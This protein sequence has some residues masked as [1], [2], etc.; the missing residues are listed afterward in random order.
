LHFRFA[1]LASVA[2]TLV[3]LSVAV[4]GAA[5]AAQ[6]VEA[7]VPSQSSPPPGPPPAPEAT[8]SRD[9]DGGAVIKSGDVIDF[10]AETMSY[11]EDSDVVTATGAVR[12]NRDAYSLA[13]DSVIYNRTTGQVEARGNVVSTDPVGNR[14]YGDR[15]LLTESLR[16]GAIDNILLVLN[17]GGRL[18]AR[19]A[20]RVNGRTTLD[21]AVY[22]PCAVESPEG[23]PKQ[24]AWEIEAVTVVHDPLKHRIS[25][26]HARL[27]MFG[28]TVIVLPGFSHPDG[29]ATRSSGLLVPE[30]DYRSE[31]G[32]SV[33]LPY[34]V[35][36][37][38]D[39]QL[40]VTPWLYSDVEP[41]LELKASQL[42]A[43]GPVQARAFFTDAPLSIY[44]ANGRTL[45]SRG[46][47]FRG[48]FE[49]NGQFQHSPEW[50][51]TFSVRLTTDNTF[52]SRYGIDYDDTLRSTV[53]LERFR[54]NS[55][56]S[57]SGWYFEG[58][59]SIDRRGITPL[60]LPLI[61]YRWDP[62]APILGGHLSVVANS[63]ALSSTDA[64]SVRRALT[65]ARWDRSVL[66]GMGQRVTLTLLG[67]GDLYD[68]VDPAK[69]TLPRYAGI[70]GFRGR[71]MP[72]GAIEAEWPF[73][74]PLKG[75]EQTIT[76]RVQLVGAPLRRNAGIP[77]EDS[78]AVDLEGVTVFSLNR[79]PGY[80]RF[81]GGSRVTYGVEY[82]YRRPK[83]SLEST[84]GQSYRLDGSNRAFPVGTGLSSTI[85]DIVGRSTIKYSDWFELTHR[86]R[87]D[88]Y[89]FAVHRTDVD[90]TVGSKRSY[91]TVG[92][93]KV[94]R[95]IV[96]EDLPNLEELRL[97]ARIAFARYW[98]VFGSTTIDLT[99]QIAEP[100][101]VT[102]GFT[103]VRHRAGVQYENE[104]FRFGL[105]WRR[106]YLSY[107]D[108][109]S[110]D[111][112]LLTLAFK[113][114]GR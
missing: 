51:T 36:L 111:T 15:V 68:T 8:T 71:A 85:S 101:S 3:G 82:S 58:L 64:Q 9:T 28:H 61:D 11:A 99:T 103:P 91:L 35:S 114:L 108:F 62:A 14:V 84:V 43:Q 23:C 73:T 34:N 50:R 59:R 45:L 22:S 97:A 21:H 47:A 77:N 55:Y 107:G 32:F 4:P 65:Y 69:A 5:V 29:A 6:A 27:R 63:E 33:A 81:E 80:D 10:S 42:F 109:R 105:S 41:A 16:D 94:A 20:V 88:G 90:V 110:G 26:K 2:S 54:S 44:A 38:S 31:L 75:G 53:A 100:T 67:R 19:S 95:S 79:F 72:Q 96:I 76:P 18:A 30:V 89:N 92:Y 83:F 66:T 102:N 98:S 39:R 93:I 86:F 106:N 13:A 104:C 49:T 12:L 40:T 37:R 52:D 48:Y 60:V 17:D 113:N 24:P 7:A 112:F 46:N 70:A 57:V 74:G 87:I 25:Y 56:L 78:R 1:L